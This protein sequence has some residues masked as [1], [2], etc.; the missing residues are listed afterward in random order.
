MSTITAPPRGNELLTSLMAA[1]RTSTTQV[2][3]RLPAVTGHG[4]NGEP[5][6]VGAGS[7]GTPI[8]LHDVLWNRHSQRFYGREPLDGAVLTAALKQ[9]SADD[10]DLWAGHGAGT[11][12]AIV[13]AA[14]RVDGL[15]PGLYRFQPEDQAYLPLAPITEADVA[16][17]VLQTEFADAPVIVA[18]VGSIAGAT[19]AHGDHGLRLLNTRAG[20]IC[21]SALLTAYQHGVIGSVFAGFL[22]S[23]LARHLRTDG[24]HQ[25]QLFAVALGHPAPVPSSPPSDTE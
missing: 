10:R 8:P 19:A 21:Y 15:E 20:S 7:L 17:M 9:A 4:P 23:G 18:S 16:D 12:V 1:V 25:G 5:V 13:V 22:P 6:T 11:E 2:V 14:L 24:Y 3:D